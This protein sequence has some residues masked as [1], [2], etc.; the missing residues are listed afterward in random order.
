MCFWVH[1]KFQ[2]PVSVAQRGICAA[3]RNKKVFVSLF[4][5]LKQLLGYAW[6]L[7]YFYNDDSRLLDSFSV[8]NKVIL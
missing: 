1:L 6:K 8:C 5:G 2:M 7:A 3:F 4:L